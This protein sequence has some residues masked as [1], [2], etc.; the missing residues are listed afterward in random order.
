[1]KDKIYMV[2]SE[3]EAQSG[4]FNSNIIG[5]FY[6]MRQAVECL[7]VER[8]TILSETYNTSFN[9]CKGVTITGKGESHLFI[10]S[11]FGDRWDSLT[12]YEKEIEQRDFIA[13]KFEYGGEFFNERIYLD[14]IDR[15]HYDDYWDWW[16]GSHGGAKH[17]NL[18][19]EVFGDKDDEGNIIYDAFEI[20][21][22]EDEDAMDSMATI[23]NF[24]LTQ[25]WLG[26]KD[27]F[28]KYY[29]NGQS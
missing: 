21:V 3:W 5:V 24:E 1:M 14:Q 8:D 2:F 27:G 4:E 23:C 22:Y 26:K 7:M 19:F 12:I 25:S 28:I 15:D 6:D 18:N 17:P 20:N 9:K 11:E 16:F 10:A 29:D 13:I